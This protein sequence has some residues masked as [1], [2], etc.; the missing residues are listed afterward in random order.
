MK[1]SNG[2]EIM[3][4]LRLLEQEMP[5]VQ[6]EEVSQEISRIRKSAQNM[7]IAPHVMALMGL[8]FTVTRMCEQMEILQHLET[9]RVQMKR[10]EAMKGEA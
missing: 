3:S 6:E 9:V 10:S 5:P 8:W 1:I 2:V 7:E 4:S